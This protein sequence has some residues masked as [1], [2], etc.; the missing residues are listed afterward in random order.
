MP[1]TLEAWSLNPWAPGKSPGGH[2]AGRAASC[3]ARGGD[4]ARCCWEKS[5]CAMDSCAPS[6]RLAGCEDSST[7]ASGRFLPGPGQCLIPRSRLAWVLHETC[8]CRQLTAASAFQEGTRGPPISCSR[9]VVH[10]RAQT[11]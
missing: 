8:L 5:V 1:P 7:A 3:A 9:Q 4:T 10:F 11:L 6:N 2:L